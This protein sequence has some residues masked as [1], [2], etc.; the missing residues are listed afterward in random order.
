MANQFN[1]IFLRTPKRN[2]FNLS[3]QNKLTMRFGELVPF[4]VQDVIPGDRF[5]V[6]SSHVIRMQPTIAP[7]MQNVNINKYYFYVPNRLL[8]S[9]WE[10]FITGGVNGTSSVDIPLLPLT[11][12]S[13]AD[14]KVFTE[15]S[16]ADYLGFPTPQANHSDTGGTNMLYADALPFMAYNLIWQEY[17]RDQNLTQNIVDFPLHSTD[18]QDQDTFYSLTSIKN[19]CWTKDE[20]T[21][22]LP[23]PQR[24]LAT[25]VP[26]DI[27]SQIDYYPGGNTYVKSAPG[28]PDIA[29]GDQLITDPNGSP[30]TTQRLSVSTTTSNVY[31]NI[32]NTENLR[33][34]STGTSLISDLRRS[35]KVQEFFEALA[36]GGSRYTEVIRRIFGIKPSDGRLQR[37]LFLGSTKC[38]MV[39]DSVAS[40]FESS[41]QVQG[42]LSG[43]GISADSKFIFN[44]QFEEHGFIIGIICVTPRASYFQGVPQKYLRDDRFKYYWPQFAHIGEQ[45]ILNSRIFYD[46]EEPVVTQDTFGYEPRYAE[47]RFNNDEVHGEF[48]TNLQ[49]WHMARNFNSTPRLNRSFVEVPSNVAD[50]TLAVDSFYSAPLLCV[51]NNNIFA[52]RKVSKYG[53]PH[54]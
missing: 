42:N 46:F 12:D 10:E 21:S 25:S 52:S 41:Q 45:P 2:K 29:D 22:A 1:S 4:M 15:G 39:M 54:L 18:L 36:S 26:I 16:L 6:G 11:T 50:R 23:W 7:I 37:P 5:K 8:W 38:N 31:S 51:I 9:D 17:F 14:K 27:Q 19:K 32:D 34:A 48:R 28:Q 44:R 40:T 33:V 24:G 30:S 47:Y 53:N 49:H 43:N 13:A 3:F 20:F 35:L